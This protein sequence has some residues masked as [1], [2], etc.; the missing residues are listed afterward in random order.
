MASQPGSSRFRALLEGAL[1]S[2]EKKAGVTLADHPLAVQ[3]RSCDSV[4]SITAFLQGQAQIFSGF[5]GHDRAMNAIKSTVSILTRLSATASLAIDFGLV[6][7][8]ALVTCSTA[9]TAF[10]AIPSRDGSTR[11]ARHPTCSMCQS[12]RTCVGALV[13]IRVNQAAKGVTSAYGALVDL[14]ESIEHFLG[15]LDIYTR[16]PPTLAMDEIVIKI[17]VELVSTLALATRELKQGRPSVSV[18]ADVLP[19]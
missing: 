1:Q 9:L 17:V 10:T 14:L 6:R 3:L 4:E 13:D 18:F 5:Q 15:R 16:I 19:Y 7:L 8:Q 2:Y 11:W 12:L